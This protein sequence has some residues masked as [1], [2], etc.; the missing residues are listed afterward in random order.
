[1]S[2][3]FKLSFLF[4]FIFSFLLVSQDE[5][6]TKFLFF[7]PTEENESKYQEFLFENAPSHE[8]FVALQRIIEKDISNDNFSG[9]LEQIDM[10]GAFFPEKADYLEDLKKILNGKRYNLIENNIGDGINSPY[11]ERTP[12]QTADER[13]MYFIGL[14]RKGFDNLTEDIF[15]SD[16]LNG[17]WTEAQKIEA[18][19]SSIDKAEAPQSITTDGNTL[20]LYRGDVGS[21]DIFYAEKTSYGWSEAKAFP[22]PINHPDYV[23][24]DA[25][26]TND[27]KHIIW[28]S[29]RPGSV[30][31]DRRW[32]TY[33]NGSLYGNTDIYISKKINDSTW[34]DPINLGESINTPYA[35]RNP[36]LHPDGK[37]LY[38]SSEGLPGI[39]RL[40]MFMSKKP[41]RDTTWTKWKKPI[42]MGFEIN[43]P[44]NDRGAIVNTMGQL[45]FFAS[46]DRDLSFGESDI[47]SVSLPEHL[48]PDAVTAI[49]GLVTDTDGFPLEA[50]IVWEDLESGEEIGRMK[51]DPLSGEFFIV[52]PNGKNYGI[53]AEREG[54]FPKSQNIN[55]KRQKESQ[56]LNENITLYQVSD[57][58]GDDL[59]M[60]SSSELLYDQ[61]KLKRKRKIKMNNLFFETNKW[62]LLPESFPELDRIVFLFKNYPIKKV[63]IQGHTDST[64]SKEYNQTLS[65]RRARAVMNY[66]IK[67]GVANNKLVSKGY[68]DEEPVETNETEEGRAANRRVEL[69]VLEAG[70]SVEK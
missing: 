32:G 6:P 45:A 41:L 57:L 54:Y 36:F 14:N 18:P 46:E 4:I 49:S 53:F 51:S 34:S 26:I 19:F 64:G 11:Q 9:A 65:G 58:L 28:V 15:Y 56:K 2:R 21:G 16:F 5:D 10:Y 24:I 13:R 44:K 17:S 68:A 59:E 37:T 62:D 38:F 20:I 40:D 8:A 23:D 12:I 3:L 66:L 7:S 1:M 50:V 39:G 31:E 52:L 29:D 70:S 30:G 61:F 48:R 22:F 67:K 55:L 63:E 27:G 60:T 47:Y 25:K 69:V 33:S 43:T 42:N 35:E